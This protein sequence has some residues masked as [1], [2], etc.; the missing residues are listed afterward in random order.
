[1]QDEEILKSVMTRTEL[2]KRII[3]AP[4]WRMDYREEREVKRSAVK[5]LE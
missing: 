4:V 1:M 5:L 2:Y 3:Q